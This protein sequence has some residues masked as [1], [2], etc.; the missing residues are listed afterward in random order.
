MPRPPRRLGLLDAMILVAAI[1]LGVAWSRF[2]RNVPEFLA[3][4][5]GSPFN[6]FNP[7]T[8]R[9][10]RAVVN[11]AWG[12][13]EVIAPCVA[14]VAIGLL[15]VRLRGPRRGLRHVFLRPG[16]SACA[17]VALALILEAIRLGVDLLRWIEED[18]HMAA[19]GSNAG[20]PWWW[21]FYGTL[22]PGDVGLA[23]SGAWMA[24]LLSGRM[25]GERSAIDRLGRAVG[26]FWIV[27]MVFS[28]AA[29]VM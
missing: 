28:W 29:G 19:I 5:F 4:P 9:P 26:I 15:I 18:R 22:R 20:A 1:A 11:R 23:V 21:E 3:N 10:V 12:W 6:A 8:D 27:T 14:T 24:L 7:A 13:F 17:A 2:L 25:R 16:A